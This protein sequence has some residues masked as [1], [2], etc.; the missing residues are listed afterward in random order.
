M[1]NDLKT[2]NVRI[3]HATPLVPA[4]DVYVNDRLVQKG[5]KYKQST[6]YL[7]FTTGKYNVKLYNTNNGDLLLNQN[8][9][10]QDNRYLTV[11][12][13]SE[14]NKVGLLSL[15]DHSQKI[16]LSYDYDE[17]MV[18]EK[19]NMMHGLENL[20]GMDQM[21]EM[22]SD[23]TFRNDMMG[24]PAYVRFVHLSP[25]APAVD[26]TTENNVLAEDIIYKEATDYIEVPAGTYTILVKPTGTNQVVLRVP[27]VTLRPD[28][29][30][31][32]YVVGLVGGTPKLEAIALVDG[33]Q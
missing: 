17:S 9:N 13:L 5:L 20:T 22:D 31:T 32:I 8:V 21:V 11:V 24:N 14:N 23:Y 28:D 18:N 10:I 27:Q 4:V 2:V 7:P 6:Q 19:L 12:A 26:I 16:D 3:F 15:P 33:M 30:K 29:V 25:N 1:Y